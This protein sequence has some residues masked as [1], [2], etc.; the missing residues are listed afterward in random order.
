MRMPVNNS[1]RMRTIA[2]RTVIQCDWHR[3]IR[4]AN[5]APGDLA[6]TVESIT[7]GASLTENRLSALRSNRAG[8]K[9][10]R[11]PVI[12]SDAYVPEFRRLLPVGETAMPCFA[13]TSR[14]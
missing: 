2:L 8:S 1:G 5:P 9:S 12:T 11:Y 4:E 14:G 7:I 6:I 13:P 3:P 10:R